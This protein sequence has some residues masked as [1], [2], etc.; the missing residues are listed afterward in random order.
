[1]FLNIGLLFGKNDY[2]LKTVGFFVCVVTCYWFAFIKVVE[3]SC[4]EGPE[5]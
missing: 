1:M 4:G 3:D 5:Q 2:I